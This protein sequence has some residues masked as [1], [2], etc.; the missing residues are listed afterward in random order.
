M[1][2]YR[3]GYRAAVRAALGAHPGFADVTVMRVW[4]GSVDVHTLPVLGVVTPNEPTSRDSQKS[5]TRR[6]L[7]QVVLRRVGG[8]DVEDRLDED[9]AVIE[10]LVYGA[11]R[12]SEL[13]CQLEDTSVV[14]HTQA[15]SI[16]GTLIM[17]FRVQSWQPE[18]NLP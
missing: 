5:T 3:S 12:G 14:A 1:P 6:T 2:H 16:V 8:D 10:A 15:E 18:P 4:P 9:S 11:L 7:L 13:K 17:S